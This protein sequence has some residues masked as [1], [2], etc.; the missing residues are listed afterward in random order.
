MRE[1]GVR[2]S[3]SDIARSVGWVAGVNT[4]DLIRARKE[5]HYIVKCIKRLQP[6]MNGRRHNIC[7]ISYHQQ[8]DLAISIITFAVTQA[9]NGS[10]GQLFQG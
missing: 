8:C 4:R 10:K 5:L 3:I 6:T 9:S 1:E 7:L 2:V